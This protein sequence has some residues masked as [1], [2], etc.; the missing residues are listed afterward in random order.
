MSTELRVTFAGLCL[1]IRHDN[2]KEMGIV[3]PDARAARADDTGQIAAAADPSHPDDTL[4]AA[5]VGY[6]RMN[7]AN[8]GDFDLPLGNIS[9][10]PRYEVVRRFD[11]HQLTFEFEGPPSRRI[12]GK[13]PLPEF[14]KV[15]DDLEPIAALFSARAPRELL[16]RTM[17]EGGRFVGDAD[18]RTWQIPPALRE[19]GQYKDDFAGSVTWIRQIDDDTQ[20]KLHLTSLDDPRQKA[21]TLALTPVDGAIEIT[22][23]NLCDNPLEWIELPKQT[24]A[25]DIDFKWLYR[26]LSPGRKTYRQRLFGAQLPFP[27]AADTNTE[28][29][30]SCTGG[31][32]T[33]TFAF[34]PGGGA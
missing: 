8:L 7:L 2:G 33:G 24:V 4:G 5:H 31:Q 22:I 30:Q 11:R 29:D 18:T 34:T 20:V 6:L 27:R 9:T 10:G 13:L 26:L 32:T 19:P 1:Y 14:S 17:V 3:M 15:G 21:E 16:F 12:Q 28:G 25:E 23:A